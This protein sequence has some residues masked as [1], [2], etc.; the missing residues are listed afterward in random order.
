MVRADLSTLRRQG[1]DKE[2]R[3]RSFNTTDNRALRE[4]AGA[5][6]AA[7]QEDPGAAAALLQSG[8]KESDEVAR[9]AEENA[10]LKAQV[11]SLQ[12]NLLVATQTSAVMSGQS[13]ATMTSAEWHQKNPTAIEILFGGQFRTFDYFLVYTAVLFPELKIERSDASQ[14]ETLTEFERYCIAVMFC[15]TDRNERELALAW[16]V[17]RKVIGRTLQK[18]MPR[19]GK[20]GKDLSRHLLDY[21]FVKKFQPKGFPER[22]GQPVA[23]AKDGTD[24]LTDTP[25]RRSLEARLLY[26]HKNDQQGGRAIVWSTPNGA[27]IFATE[28]FCARG[29]EQRWWRPTGVGSSTSQRGRATSSTAGS[30]TAGSTTRTSTVPT[31]QRSSASASAFSVARLRTPVRSRRIATRPR[32]TT[33]ASKP[34]R[35]SRARSRA[36]A[37]N[38]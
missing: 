25:R 11:V 18:W 33:R 24:F 20:V 28:V 5:I 15:K 10:S 34:K 4:T 9:L 7:A 26:G 2:E 27:S 21:D 22:Y 13:R 3:R 29:G 38:T 16:G 14:N 1:E 19:L 12:S 8:V 37:F 31:S 23:M 36:T 32:R 35:L 30:S 17:G 6:A